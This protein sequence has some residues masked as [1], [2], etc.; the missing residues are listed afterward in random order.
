MKI[1]AVDSAEKSCSLALVDDG[2]PVCEE[3]YCTGTTHSSTLMDMVDHM[4]CKR[5]GIS[6]A[7]IDGFA[8][9]KG[10]GSFTGLRIGIS[11]VK[12][13]AFAAS[14]PCA[15][16]SSLDGI[17]WQ[18]A[19]SVLP[20]CAMMDAKRGEVYCAVY[21]FENCELVEKSIEMAVSPEDAADYAGKNALFAGSGAVVFRDIIKKRLG[22]DSN[23]VFV[24]G[25]LNHV[26]AAALAEVLF[27]DPALL[28]HDPCAVMPVYL[29]R[30]D[31]EINSKY[32]AG[33]PI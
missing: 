28:S 31:A 2:I 32:S 30:S 4:L 12:G 27:H 15:G 17:A 25:F 18:M 29:R 5:A 24:P 8:V 9:A 7:D 10:P 26:R 11:V 33:T 3:F 6:G 16:I 23:P 20:V 19:A 21:R 22:P 14:K 1:L 13:L